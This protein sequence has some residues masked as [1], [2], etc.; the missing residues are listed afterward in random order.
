VAVA[1]R[2]VLAAVFA[3]AAATKLADRPGFRDALVAFGAPGR[4]ARP[5]ALI[6][7]LAELTVAALLVPAPTALVGAIGALVLL[8]VFSAAI[9]WNLAHGRTPACHC[10]GQLHSAPIG[11][12]ALGRNAVLG[13]VALAAVVGSLEEPDASAVAWIGDLGGAQLLAVVVAVAAVAL[14]AV[15]TVAFLTLMRSYGR[16]LVRLDRL[17]A[18]LADA[19]IDFDDEP[20]PEIGLEPGTRAPAFSGL[21]ELLAP[22][23][24]VLLLF[25]SPNCGPCEALLPQAAEWQRDHADVLTVA[26]ASDGDAEDV[27]AEAQELGLERVLVDRERRIYESF[28]ANGTPSAVLVSADGTIASWVAS[29]SEWIERLVADA[30]AEPP[31][32]VGLPVG[33]PAP[34]IALTTLEGERMTVS[35][36]RG[37]DTLLLFWNPD[38]GFC[39]SMHEDLIAR[40]A[41]QNGGP[42]LVV[43]S[44]G[45]AEST[46]AEGFSSQVLLDGHFTAGSAFGAN[47]T[48]MAVLLDAEGRIASRVVAG[49]EAVLALARAE[50]A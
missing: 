40:E 2:I 7:P 24:P 46:S 33:A 15:G 3:V 43:V 8:G 26:F 10:F 30:T 42:R 19:G 17:E 14:L 16:V 6:L 22:G 41:S 35:E 34:E 12:R 44:S 1:A 25:T 28:E 13:L 5:L 23:L 37:D 50:P 29:G 31:E 9:G 39:R 18:A 11:W 21:D 36:L 38:C 49:A 27:R 45:D 4:I 32:D 47:G 20:L 48:P